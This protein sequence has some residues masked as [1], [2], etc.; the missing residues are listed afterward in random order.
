MAV[1]QNDELF[2]LLD[3]FH[4]ET[5]S[6]GY[7]DTGTRFGK[8]TQS[9]AASTIEEKLADAGIVHQYSG[10]CPLVATHV[11]WDFKAG[12]DPNEVGKIAAKNNVKIGSINPN[13]FQDQIYKFGSATSPV[14]A[15][16]EAANSHVEDCL[17]IARAVDSDCI[18]F[19]MA[20]G[21][22]YPGQDDIIARKK[23]LE[24]AFKT[25]T[26]QC[27]KTW[28]CWSNTSRLNP[29]SITPIL[30]IG[31]WRICSPRKPAERESAGGYRPSFAGHQYRAHCGD[32]A[33]RKYVGRLSFQRPQICRR[34]FDI[35]FD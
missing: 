30:P 31:A 22:N 4:I 34:R 23:R 26:T 18:S 15:A 28:R 12:V 9:A 10:C 6:W 7:A 1:I 19:W 17:E 5:P 27:P 29:R 13:L 21:T 8:F 3:E 20:D 14:D 11:L 16:R 32:F 35:G 24:K 2:Q 33:G 25:G